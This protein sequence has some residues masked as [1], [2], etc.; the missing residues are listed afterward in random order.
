[1]TAKRTFD[2][3]VAGLGL[4]ASS[5]LWLV[6]AALVKIESRGPVFFSQTRVGERGRTFDAL[7]FRSMVE[8][9]ERGVGPLQATANDPRVT[10]V[11]RLLRDRA[12]VLGDFGPA[13]APEAGQVARRLDRPTGGRRQRKD[14]RNA[15]L[16]DHR[17]PGKSEQGLDAQGDGRP[18][19]G[20]IVDVMGRSGRRR[21]MCRGK[22]GKLLLPLPAG[23]RPQ[24]RVK[25]IAA[26]L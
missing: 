24:R 1:M 22:P 14:Q 12:H 11:G 25:R 4:A 3:T 26:N 19:F 8:D 15:I 5:P 17:M 23:Q 21:E 20:G 9:A 7:K 6:I 13:S 18:G 2:V 16:A 10:R